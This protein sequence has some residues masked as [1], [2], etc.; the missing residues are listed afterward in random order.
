MRY[1]SSITGRCK[2]SLV[3]MWA[4]MTVVTIIVIKDAKHSKPTISHNT[5]L[6][7]AI[8]YTNPTYR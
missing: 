6:Q 4:G 7:T 5:E 1:A 3:C 8:V 2:M